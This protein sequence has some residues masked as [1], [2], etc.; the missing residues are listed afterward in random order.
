MDPFQDLAR[1]TE[2]L[3]RE[4]AVQRAAIEKLKELAK[5]PA[6]ETHIIE[7]PIRRTA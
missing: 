6:P 2:I 7:M 5:K 3:E 1:K 4:L